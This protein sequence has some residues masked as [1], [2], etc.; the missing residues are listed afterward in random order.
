[1]HTPAEHLAPGQVGE[2]PGEHSACGRVHRWSQQALASWVWALSCP[3][4]REQ[5]SPGEVFWPD[6]CCRKME[7]H[8]LQQAKKAA[9]A[10]LGRTAPVAG[11]PPFPCSSPRE[12]AGTLDTGRGREPGPVPF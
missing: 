6:L 3:T 7:Q 10:R 1:M 4:E 8:L 5:S 12:Q 2:T 11:L 9:Y